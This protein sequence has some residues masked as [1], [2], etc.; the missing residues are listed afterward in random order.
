LNNLFD[1]SSISSGGSTGY[2]A[3]TRSDAD[4][5]SIDISSIVLPPRS[6]YCFGGLAPDIRLPAPAAGIIAAISIQDSIMDE[7]PKGKARAKE[8][9]LVE[10]YIRPALYKKFSRLALIVRS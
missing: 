4:I 10:T 7:D 9:I 8:D 2:T 3:S 6:K 5:A 1:S